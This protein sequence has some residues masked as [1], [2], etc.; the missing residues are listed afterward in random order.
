MPRAALLSG[1]GL[2]LVALSIGLMLRGD[3][4][5]IFQ[6]LDDRWAHWVGGGKSGAAGSFALVLDR[7]GGP[8]G[9]IFPLVLAGVLC[10]YGRWR[11]GLFAV[12]A[13]LVA[14]ML[15]V[16]PLKSLVDRPRP[17]HPLV[18]VNDGSYPSGQVFA[19]VTLVVAV[20]VVLFPPRAR[21]WWWLFGAA[22]VVAMMWSR[23][24]L[25]TQWLSDAAA[26]ALAGGGTALLVHTAFA[27]LLERE[28]ELIAANRL[29]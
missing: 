20:G 7:L 29:W 12:T 14:N 19:A 22:Y 6:S 9:A 26:G 27:P 25:Q 8:L 24:Y 4:P 28:A 21:H 17:P 11:S 23:T 18:L 3:G 16:L 15:V 2:L 13:A 1:T 10:V 5:A